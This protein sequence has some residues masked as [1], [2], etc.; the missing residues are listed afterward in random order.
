M[1]RGGV[2]STSGCD[3][4]RGHGQH[5]VQL[6]HRRGAFSPSGCDSVWGQ[7]GQHGA[8]QMH[9]EGA[10]STSGC[11]FTWGHDQHTPQQPH[12]SGVLSVSGH[13]AWSAGGDLHSW[14]GASSTSVL[15][16]IKSMV[17]TRAVAVT[18]GPPAPLTSRAGSLFP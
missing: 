17:L 4:L 12:R 8:Q 11:E 18:T 5:G 10:F 16:G 13:P 3:S 7:Q 6:M 9:R 15:P 1:H 2:F 14:P